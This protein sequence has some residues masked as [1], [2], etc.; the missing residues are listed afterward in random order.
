MDDYV[1]DV[2]TD[3]R[4][5]YLA[6][7]V[8]NMERCVMPWLDEVF[9]ETLRACALNHQPAEYIRSMQAAMKEVKDWNA[10]A[11]DRERAR[12]LQQCPYMADLLSCAVVTLVKL[13]SCGRT[14]DRRKN[15]HVPAP[16]LDPFVHRVYINVARQV[17]THPYLFEATANDL[18]KTKQRAER[19]RVVRGCV[20]DTVRNGLGVPT[21]AIL[22]AYQ[23]ES[24]ENEEQVFIEPI[25]PAKR[26]EAEELENAKR[27]ALGQDPLVAASS[28]SAAAVA[29][30]QK[31]QDPV[32]AMRRAPGDVSFDANDN[33]AASSGGD[34][35]DENMVVV[36]NMDDAPIVSRVEFSPTNEVFSIPARDDDYAGGEGGDYYNTDDEYQNSPRNISVP[37]DLNANLQSIDD[38]F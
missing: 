15:I 1:Q 34:A 5:E 11:L 10:V 37:M 25:A 16:Q 21:E 9:A 30:A 13:L 22:R 12:V 14:T 38:L 29:A 20:L 26:D 36:R 35:D 28:S 31:L 2:L 7:L 27:R 32:F 19:E 24:V 23:E 3:S 17:F 8:Q 18:E 4:D 6:R 33:A